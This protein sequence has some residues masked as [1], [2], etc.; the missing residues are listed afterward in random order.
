MQWRSER[1]DSRTQRRNATPRS[2]ARFTAIVRQKEMITTYYAVCVAI[3]AAGLFRG[4]A[5]PRTRS[6]RQ[7]AGTA[8]F[9]ISVAGLVGALALVVAIVGI[10][11]VFDERTDL[12]NGFDNLFSVSR[13]I[14][15]TCTALALAG[16]TV[17]FLGSRGKSTQ[18]AE[19]NP[20]YDVAT[21][22]AHED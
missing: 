16:H 10:A 12:T 5:W 4:N 9:W 3:L 18:D 15:S 8:L 2:A 11:A 14:A 6:T 1:G 7:I 22:A 21:R 13:Q 17:V 19:P 20:A